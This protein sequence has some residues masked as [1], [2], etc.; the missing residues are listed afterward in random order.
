MIELDFGKETRHRGIRSAFGIAMGIATWF[1]L[2]TGFIAVIGIFAG[3]IAIVV[4]LILLKTQKVLGILR[5]VLAALPRGEIDEELGVDIRMN[6]V[7]AQPRYFTEELDVAQGKLAVGFRLGECMEDPDPAVIRVFNAVYGGCLT[8]K[9][10]MNVRERLNLSYSVNSACDSFKGIMQ[11]LAGIEF[12]KYDEALAEIFAQLD[13]VR[14]GDITEEELTA[15]KNR[16]ASSLRGLSD[17]PASLESFYTD[18][19][20]LGLFCTPEEMAALVEDVTK[21]D[22]VAAAQ[23]IRLDAVYFLKGE[24]DE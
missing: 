23:G 9:L 10:F 14:N 12:E 3:V 11:V 4:G 7:E 1:V 6:A 17:S 5:D 22:V 2:Q 13:A 21:E 16:I 20:V 15:C 19:A 18:E 24:S 8:S